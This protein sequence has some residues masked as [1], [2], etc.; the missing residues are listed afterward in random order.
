MCV[1][2]L[3]SNSLTSELLDHVYTYPTIDDKANIVEPGQ[4]VRL[5]YSPP[6]VPPPLSSSNIYSS[7]NE[8]LD[9][10]KDNSGIT[11]PQG[12]E[13]PG[14]N[15]EIADSAIYEYPCINSKLEVCYTF[16]T[17]RNV[18]FTLNFK[19]TMLYHGRIP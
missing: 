4:S 17:S 9:I 13:P 7:I 10:K 8:E 12:S 1:Y 15:D 5:S 11:T 6:Q 14:T 18:H 3:D 19:K 2:K 16:V